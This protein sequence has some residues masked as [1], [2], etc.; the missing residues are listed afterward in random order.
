VKVKNLLHQAGILVL[1]LPPYS[2]DLD[3]IEEA[4]NYVKT[5]LKKHEVHL[6][7][8]ATIIKAAF[9]S[10]SSDHYNAWITDSG[11]QQN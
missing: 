9:E 8:L 1:F 5:Y 2:Q 3:P 11:Y 4:F 6:Q 10:V 7:S